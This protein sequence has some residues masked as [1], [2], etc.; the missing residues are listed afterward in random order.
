MP[1]A[2]IHTCITSLSMYACILL[3]LFQSMWVTSIADAIGMVLG[4]QPFISGRGSV[5]NNTDC[6][7]TIVTVCFFVTS[8]S[9]L[10][11][12]IHCIRQ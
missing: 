9:I 3:S 12:L 6:T 8:Y 10:I 4:L 2:C 1:N 7:V 5:D 11:V